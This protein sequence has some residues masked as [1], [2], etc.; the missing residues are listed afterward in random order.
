MIVT[1]VTSL[2]KIWITV[3]KNINPFINNL[4]NTFIAPRI[5]LSARNGSF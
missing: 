3:N 1:L 4:K 2:Q 5:L